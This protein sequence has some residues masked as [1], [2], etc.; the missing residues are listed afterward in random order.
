MPLLLAYLLRWVSLTFLPGLASNVNPPNFYFL[1]NWDYRHVS[2]CP[3]QYCDYFQQF[4]CKIINLKILKV[5]MMIK[6]KINMKTLRAFLHTNK[7]LLA[8]M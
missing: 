5:L 4:D 7:K 2:S 6:H 1:N 3:A 8:N